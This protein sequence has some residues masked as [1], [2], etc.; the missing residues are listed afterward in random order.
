VLNNITR[1][2][3]SSAVSFVYH[4]WWLGFRELGNRC[5]VS[6]GNSYFY[7]KPPRA[8]EYLWLDRHFWECA[9]CC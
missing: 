5:C 1:F 7:L 6:L 8:A 9:L 2:A 3:A 4:L